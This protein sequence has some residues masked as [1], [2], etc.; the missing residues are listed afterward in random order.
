MSD[1]TFKTPFK[2]NREEVTQEALAEF[3]HLDET[4]KGMQGRHK[5]MKKM[6]VAH[7]DADGSVESG[8]LTATLTEKSSGK[9]N[10]GNFAEAKGLMTTVI[11]AN[12][13]PKGNRYNGDGTFNLSFDR[14]ARLFNNWDEF[15]SFLLRE[16]PAAASKSLVIG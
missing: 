2:N 4:L 15:Q 14:K 12:E 7:L 3:K 16:F 6:L 5:R 1:I 8:D 11:V 10:M 13:I 9:A